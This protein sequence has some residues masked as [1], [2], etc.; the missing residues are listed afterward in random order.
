MGGTCIVTG[1]SR[2][3]GRAISINL[4]RT[5]YYDNYILMARDTALLKETKARMDKGN[6]T[7]CL[8]MDLVELDKIE[9]VVEEIAGEFGGIHALI[10]V[11]GFVEPRSLLETTVENWEKTFKINVSSVFLL[12]REVVRHMKSSGGKIVN[13]ASTAGM[14]PRPGWLAYAAS[15][16]AVISMSQ[17][18][19]DELK[20]YGIKVYCIS[21]GRCATDLRKVLAPEEDP[22]TIM[23]PE[24]V[25]GFISDLL[26]PQG[27]ILD[28]QNIVL[29]KQ[30]TR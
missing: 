8:P 18:L 23:Q 22:S 1:A 24:D 21:P 4:S 14:T 26:S 7:V 10:N 27:D 20:E 25:A 3:I 17:T 11:A 16:A 30:I 29:R 2:G 28:S 13:F 15:K 12:T 6:N 9:P 5:D 19:S